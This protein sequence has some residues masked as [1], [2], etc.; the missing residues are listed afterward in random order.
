[1]VEGK[2]GRI[3]IKNRRKILLVD[4]ADVI[5]IEARGNYAL[6]HRPS[7]SLRLR[8]SFS[9]VEEKLNSYGF[10][11]PPEIHAVRTLWRLHQQHVRDAGRCI[12]QMQKALIQMN[13]Q[14]HIA[15]SDISGVSG[16]AIIRA[17][18]KRE[19][20]AKV[21]ATLRV[22]RC[23]AS[24][25]EIVQSLRGNSTHRQNR[26]SATRGSGTRGGRKNA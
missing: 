17:L 19:R 15:L 25:E 11:P 9:V 13:V 8:E 6:L 3:A 26:Q 23:Q 14:L 22:R 18:L 16:Q 21:L 2:Q 4:M 20:D 5:A 1:M 12:Q 7:G 10:L 24:E